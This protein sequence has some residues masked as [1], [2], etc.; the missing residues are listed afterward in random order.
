M[1][2]VSL[3]TFSLSVGSLLMGGGNVCAEED[4]I[5]FLVFSKKILKQCKLICPFSLASGKGE[6]KQHYGDS[7][8]IPQLGESV[9]WGICG[10]NISG[11]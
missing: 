4:Y 5:F 3:Y 2:T 10:L 1:F 7:R 11:T 9:L 8:H 6:R